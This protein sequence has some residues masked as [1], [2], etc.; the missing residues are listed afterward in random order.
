MHERG[1]SVIARTVADAELSA[2]IAGR[3][4]AE[5]DER[6]REQSER[7]HKTTNSTFVHDPHSIRRCERKKILTTRSI[8]RPETR[9]SWKQQ[10][11]A[12][13]ARADRT[14]VTVGKG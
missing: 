14:I 10:V 11:P 3:R 7:E 1:G 8:D 13:P 9:S 4:F 6:Q 12:R 5:P 2:A